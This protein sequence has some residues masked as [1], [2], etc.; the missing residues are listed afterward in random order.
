[1][2]C[3][4]PWKRVPVDTTLGFRLFNELGQGTREWAAQAS[5]CRVSV[6]GFPAQ[7]G[8][9]GAASEGGGQL[10]PGRRAVATAGDRPTARG[11]NF[12]PRPFLFAR[13]R[14]GGRH[15]PAASVFRSQPRVIP[16]AP[17]RRSGAAGLV[18]SPALPLAGRLE[19]QLDTD[20][21]LE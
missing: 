15:R 2:L 11:R 7:V 3:K 13:P 5:A 20:S 19:A 16:Q 1:M 4:A 17:R 12:P 18:A 6:P 8:R 10:L 14:G 9:V 21:D